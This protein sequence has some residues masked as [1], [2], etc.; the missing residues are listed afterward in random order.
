[1][2][3]RMWFRFAIGILAL[4]TVVAVSTYSYNLGLARGLA[5]N[6]RSITFAPGPWGFGFGF[7]PLFPFLFIFFWFFVLRGLFWRGPWGRRAWHHDGVPPAF[8]EWHRRAHARQDR[9][10]PAPDTLEK[11]PA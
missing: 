9:P 10:S 8:D 6:G 1:M 5:D 11:D 4:A 7:F 3:N 2:G